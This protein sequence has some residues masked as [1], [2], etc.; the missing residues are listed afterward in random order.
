MIV[1]TLWHEYDFASETLD[2]YL[3][4]DRSVAQAPV[5][6]ISWRERNKL[7]KSRAQLGGFYI[8]DEAAE[9]LRDFFADL[10]KIDYED[11]MDPPEVHLTASTKCLSR[12]KEAAAADLG[13]RW[14]RLSQISS[15]SVDKEPIGRE[16]HDTQ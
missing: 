11:V 2:Y 13:I 12:I 5:R 9:A 15:N 8:S 14:D 4:W 16:R 1:D 10:A 3:E 6:E 7:L